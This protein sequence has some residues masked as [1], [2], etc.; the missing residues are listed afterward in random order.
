MVLFLQLKG[1]EKSGANICLLNQTDRV[2]VSI[3][4]V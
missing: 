2:K 4:L 3:P 1:P